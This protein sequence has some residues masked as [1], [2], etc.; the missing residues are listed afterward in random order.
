MND[1]YKT[2]VSKIINDIS[3]WYKELYEEQ[4]E[5]GKDSLESAFSKEKEKVILY[6]MNGLGRLA[7][8]YSVE[9][10]YFVLNGNDDRANLAY[11]KA[12]TYHYLEHKSIFVASQKMSVPLSHA[13][14]YYGNRVYIFVVINSF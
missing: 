9:G 6:V 13:S 8:T 12:L 7:N 11:S 10:A 5:S 14:S 1:I 2:K 3:S 4:I